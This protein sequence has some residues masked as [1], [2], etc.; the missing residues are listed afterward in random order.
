[1]IDFTPNPH[2]KKR[3]AHPKRNMFKSGHSPPC[4]SNTN[5]VKDR[6]VSGNCSTSGA[7]ARASGLVP[8]AA[9]TSVL[10]TFL[11][12]ISGQGHSTHGTR[13]RRSHLSTQWQS[14]AV[15]RDANF[16]TQRRSPHLHA[17]GEY[18]VWRKNTGRWP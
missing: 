16:V 6:I 9:H 7:V 12:K 8:N 17:E 2:P 11:K 3:I 1:M 5:S 4:P 14:P 18:V 15:R 13:A 10:A